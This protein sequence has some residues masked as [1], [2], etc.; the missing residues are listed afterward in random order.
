MLVLI[1][2]GMDAALPFG[3]R[4]LFASRFFRAHQRRRICTWSLRPPHRWRPC[5][6]RHR[7]RPLH[8][9]PHHRHHA[10]FGDCLRKAAE[11]RPVVRAWKVITIVVISI[12]DS[13]NIS[14]ADSRIS[15]PFKVHQAHA[16]RGQDKLTGYTWVFRI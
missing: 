14:Y 12:T 1:N 2:S 3:S 13:E 6:H 10:C 8:G 9:L 7:L 16:S 11:C 5:Y 4:Q 15:I